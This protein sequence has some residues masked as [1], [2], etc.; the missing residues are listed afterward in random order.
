MATILN[1]FKIDDLGMSFKVTVRVIHPF[2]MWM[3]VKTN[4]LTFLTLVGTFAHLG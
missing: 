3:H 1:D 2:S 4:F